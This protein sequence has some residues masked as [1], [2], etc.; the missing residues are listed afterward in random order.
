MTTEIIKKNGKN[1]AVIPYDFYQQL[2]EDA[3]MLADIKA[4][5][6][7]KNKSEESFPS[8]VV[9]SIFLKGENPIKIYREYRGISILEL[10]QKTNIDIQ[11]LEKIEDNISMAT[12]KNLEVIAESLN[13]DVDMII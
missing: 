7:A 8:E 12:Q 1:Y 4:Y 9:D 5:D 10:S 11:E 6:N 2:I 3:E 13:I